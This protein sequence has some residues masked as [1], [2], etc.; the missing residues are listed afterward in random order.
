MGDR[1][2]E[3]ERERAELIALLRSETEASLWPMCRLEALRVQSQTCNTYDVI[4]GL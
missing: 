1:S 2:A 3:A 4:G